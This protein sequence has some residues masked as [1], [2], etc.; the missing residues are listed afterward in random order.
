[1]K[2]KFHLLSGIFYLL[3]AGCCLQSCQQDLLDDAFHDREKL[4]AQGHYLTARSVDAF[5]LADI[6]SGPQPFEVGTPYRL[7][8]FSKRYDKAN[9]QAETPVATDPRFNKVA[10]EGETPE[11]LRFI[12]I[13]QTPDQWFGFSALNGEEKGDDGLVSLDFYGFTYGRAEVPASDYIPVDGWADESTQLT[14]LKRTESVTDGVLKDL[15]RGMLLNQNISTAGVQ[16]TEADGNQLPNAHTQSVL[17]FHHCFSKL[18][19]QISQQGKENAKDEPTFKNLTVEKIEVTGTY[20]TGT[21]SLADGKVQVSGEKLDRTLAFN[22]QFNGTVTTT[23]SDVGEM[24]L[25]PSDG[26]S[27]SNPELSDGYYVGL[28]ITVKSTVKK[29]IENMLKN[30][31][32]PGTVEEI[33]GEPGWFRGTIVK[34]EITDYYKDVA[35][36][37]RALYFKQNTAYMLIIT[38]QDDAVRI[39]TVIPMIEE[40]LPGEGTPQDPWQ[41]Q[42]MGQPQMFNNIV[43]SD[44]NLGADDYDPT[45]SD[46]ERSIGYFYQAGRNIPYYPFYFNKYGSGGKTPTYADLKEPQN[47]K[48][49]NTDW[50]TMN[51]R[52]SPVVDKRLLKMGKDKNNKYWWVISRK[53]DLQENE[54]H[55][56]MM[57]IPEKCPTADSCFDFMVDNT[58]WYDDMKWNEGQANQ[59]VAGAWVIPTSKEFLSIFPSTPHA[60]NIVFNMVGMNSGN[61]GDWGNDGWQ[62]EP[63]Y[64]MTNIDVIRVTV[65]FYNAKAKNPQPA[66]SNQKY[67]EAWQTLVNN[68]DEGTTHL[69]KYIYNGYDGNPGNATFLEPDGGDPEDGY[70]S[71][72]IISKA[73]EDEVKLSD[74]LK[75]Q[76][77]SKG[78]RFVVKSWGTIYGIKKIYTPGA[79]RMRW[80]ALIADEGT[81]NPSIYLEIC[82]YRCNSNDTLTEANYK[83]YDWEHP[84]ATLYIPVCGLGDYTGEYINYGIECQYATSD[85]IFVDPK[86]KFGTTSAVQIKLTGNNASNAY[87][88]VVKDKINR[89]LGKQIRPIIGG[90]K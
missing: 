61:V 47:F 49:N 77:T 62:N 18:R 21:V 43:W 86:T 72:Y 68:H 82:R 9:P 57:R 89:H 34:D 39:I 79:Y 45:G 22:E 80:R 32:S 15:M 16:G 87:I 4:I 11:K 7:F 24:L 37:N 29:D 65:P 60:G 84:A 2:R 35:E 74:A 41:T 36:Q 33:P 19:F 83:T 44:R 78:D 30:T 71:V 42:E 20:P 8:A 88:A 64:Q 27:L 90:G 55:F 31:N 73:G 5:A 51:Y 54:K 63:D 12:N 52:F 13:D 76:K 40:W 70:A 10:W 14:A 6:N 3:A 69:E 67:K 46:F 26:S 56:P 28:K 85:P 17:P 25:F 59:P 38:F 81:M 50:N 48:N 1:M 75:D 53:D 66:K 58:L 23:N